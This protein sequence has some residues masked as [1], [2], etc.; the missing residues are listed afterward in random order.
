MASG[1]NVSAAGRGGV[2]LAIGRWRRH[3]GAR[4]WAALALALLALWTADARAQDRLAGTDQP[5]VVTADALRFDR[6]TDTVAAE[7]SVELTQGDRRL[8]ADVVTYSA[9]NDRVT[10]KG[11]VTLIEPT[12]EILFADEVE[13]TGEMRNGMVQRLRALLADNARLA[14]ATG[15]RKDGVTVFSDGVYSPCPICADGK[16]LPLW[17]VRAGTIEHDAATQDITYRNARMELF[18]VPVAWTPWFRH[19]DPEVKRRSGFL[20]PS[21]GSSSTLGLTYSQP[22]H[23]VLAPNRDVTLTP[24]LSTKKAPVLGLEWRE[25][26]PSGEMR[27][28]GSFTRTDSYAPVGR[29]VD[30]EEWRGHVEGRGRFKVQDYDAGFDLGLASDNSYLTRYRFGNQDV[31]NNHAFMQKIMGRD[32]VGLHAYAFQGLR[33]G[34]DQ[35]R[36]PFVL[37]LIETRLRSSKLRWGSQLALDTSLVALTRQEGLDTRRL[38][39]E[40]RWRVPQLGPIGDIWG[41]ELSARGDV[42]DYQGDART[43]DDN[44]ERQQEGRF[45][46]RATVDWSWPLGGTAGSWSHIV[47]PTAMATMAPN[48]GNEDN[49]PNEDS[50]VFEFDDTNLFKPSRFTGLDRVDG[51]TKLA[52]GLRF[53]SVAPSG[54]ELSGLVGQSYQVRRNETVPGDTGVTKNFSDLVGRV[55]FRPSDLVDIRYR[56]RLDRQDLELRR[57]DLNL[58]LGPRAMRFDIGWLRL[59]D[60]PTGLAPRS[61]EELTAGVRIQIMD[62][63]AIG[64]RTRQDLNENKPVSNML[65][66]IYT[67]PCLVLVAGMEKSFTRTGEVDDE[68]SFKFRL[69]FTGF[70]GGDTSD[71]LFGR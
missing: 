36:I 35:D 13:L 3:Q 56:F 59:S 24:L 32:Y 53:N 67:H 46:P 12:G 71:G 42:Y 66:L 49:F 70:G 5:V 2:G 41:L 27:L 39:S 16:G 69:T 30:G 4:P 65:G 7:G 6:K 14:S 33:E 15:T 25:R 48:R 26:Q 64:A 34:D 11:N 9:T 10:A 60:E 63:L 62:N 21:A 31:L 23:W 58:S 68:L 8:L 29:N 45:V 22:Y 19:P 57:S 17:Q 43:F 54:M 1:G 55:D 38:S 61:R 47:E 28:A 50:Q 40:A 52:Y 44:G 51:G 37:P 18:G 20:T